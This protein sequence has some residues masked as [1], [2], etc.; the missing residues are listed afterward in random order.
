MALERKI[1]TMMKNRKK[2][3]QANINAD[4]IKFQFLKAYKN[5]GKLFFL[6]PQNLLFASA[7]K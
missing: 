3:A 6:L 5:R 4:L 1:G 7:L 2:T